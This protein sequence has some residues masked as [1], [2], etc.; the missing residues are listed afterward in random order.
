MPIEIHEV[1]YH[2][3]NRHNWTGHASIE[4]GIAFDV[5]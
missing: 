3:L 2:E 1:L 4:V 5:Q